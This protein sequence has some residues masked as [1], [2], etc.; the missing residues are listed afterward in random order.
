MGSEALVFTLLCWL[1]L[2]ESYAFALFVL[3]SFLFLS[4]YSS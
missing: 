3:Y 4:S 1:Y 2:E